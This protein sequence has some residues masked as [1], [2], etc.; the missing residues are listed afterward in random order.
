MKK[1]FAFALALLLA[2]CSSISTDSDF[3]PQT[4]F[5]QYKTWSWIKQASTPGDKQYHMD[6]LTDQ[7]IRNAVTRKMSE[8]GFTQ[9]AA[10]EADILVNYLTQTEKKVNVDTF[11]TSFGYHPYHYGRYPYYGAANVHADTRVREYKVGTLM[12]DFVDAESRQLI[13]RGSA[14]DTVRDYKTPEDRTAKIN[15]AVTAIL[16]QYPPG[17]GK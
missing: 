17:S 16:Q 6:G 1:I 13:W 12:V 8:L 2:G 9:V 7:R 10:E 5:S 4:D 15:E 11:Y 14:S 3:D